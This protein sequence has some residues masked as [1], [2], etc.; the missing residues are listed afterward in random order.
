MSNDEKRDL[1]EVA[2]VAADARL[3][4]KTKTFH[5][6]LSWAAMDIAMDTVRG[7]LAGHGL[8]TWSNGHAT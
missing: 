2:A 3:R 7:A 6:W 5:A 1:G 4:P 8:H